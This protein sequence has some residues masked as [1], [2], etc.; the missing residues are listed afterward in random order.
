MNRLAHIATI[1]LSIISIIAYIIYYYAAGY[2]KSKFA[3]DLTALVAISFMAAA[4]TPAAFKALGRGARSD[5]DKFL[6]SYWSVWTVILL[7][8]LWIIYLGLHNK[9]ELMETYTALRESMTSG[10]MAIMF[11]ISGLHGMTAPF[12]GSVVPNKRDIIIFSAASGFSGVIAGMAIG[13]F[14]IAGWTN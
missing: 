13:V 8:R 10:L 3:A 1:W 5:S 14:I 11:A 6:I 2:I 7:Q 4:T 9:P 12:S